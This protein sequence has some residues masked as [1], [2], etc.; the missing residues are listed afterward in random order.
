MVLL[1]SKKVELNRETKAK[2]I[3]FCRW[4][5]PIFKFRAGKGEINIESIGFLEISS[6]EISSFIPS[7]SLDF[8]YTSYFYKRRKAILW[9][10]TCQTGTTNQSQSWTIKWY[11]LDQT[12][13]KIWTFFRIMVVFF[14]CQL[15]LR[16]SRVLSTEYSRIYLF[17]LVADTIYC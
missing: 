15:F 10:W 11:S 3:H 14:V 12:H 8:L 7:R 5:R 16:T 4:T 13:G 1:F 17:S 6:R 9:S 2:N